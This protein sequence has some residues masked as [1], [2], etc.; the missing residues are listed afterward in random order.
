MHIEKSE[1]LE[2][3]RNGL[4]VLIFVAVFYAVLLFV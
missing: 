3:A 2:A 1:L 4:S